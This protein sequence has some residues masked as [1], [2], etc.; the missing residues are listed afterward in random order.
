MKRK[1][2]SISFTPHP[3]VLRYIDTLLSTGLHG[4]SRSEVVKRLVCDGIVR[5]IGHP[6]FTLK[7]TR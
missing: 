2:V 6:T 7:E 5:R 1:T 4:R 3:K